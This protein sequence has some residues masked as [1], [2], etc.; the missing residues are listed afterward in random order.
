M[1][2]IKINELF[3]DNQ[4]VFN[5]ANGSFEM[6]FK[7]KGVKLNL[8]GE[9]DYLYY[10]TKNA[11]LKSGFEIDD[12]ASK[13]LIINSK[14]KTWHIDNKEFTNIELLVKYLNS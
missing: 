6:P 12:K 5:K 4:L 9:Q 13:E 10:W 3:V 11:L 2:K 7:S 14:N 1:L 8:K